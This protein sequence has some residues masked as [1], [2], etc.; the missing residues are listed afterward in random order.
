MSPLNDS[1]QGAVACLAADAEIEKLKPHYLDTLVIVR[2]VTRN[3]K[4]ETGQLTGIT[5]TTIKLYNDDEDTITINRFSI[6]SLKH[7]FV[8]PMTEFVVA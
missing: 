1:E 3:G 5:N 2:V 7:D 6:E 4:Y 8:R